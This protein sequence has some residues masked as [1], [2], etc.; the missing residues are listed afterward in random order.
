MDI[1]RSPNS[2]F[3]A[4]PSMSILL[5]HEHQVLALAEPGIHRSLG[6]RP[7]PGALARFASIEGILQLPTGFLVVQDFGPV[8]QHYLT[9]D[10][11]HRA[12]VVQRSP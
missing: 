5:M 8:F 1:A 7:P 10:V 4:G 2:S 3:G 12:Q 11:G 9:Q 6:E